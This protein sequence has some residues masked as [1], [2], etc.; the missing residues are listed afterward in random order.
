MRISKDKKGQVRVQY[1]VIEDIDVSFPRRTWRRLKK[2][3]KQK[4]TDFIILWCIQH[5]LESKII[6][7]VLDKVKEKK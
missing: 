4:D 6:L 3:Y 2:A 5:D 1:R 7:K